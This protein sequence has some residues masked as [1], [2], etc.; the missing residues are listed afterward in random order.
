MR[1]KLSLLL[2]FPG[3]LLMIS[4]LIFP[5][6]LWIREGV[7]ENG[8]YDL[9]KCDA[10]Y[11]KIRA[12][13]T[14]CISPYAISMRSLGFGSIRANVT[15]PIIIAEGHLNFSLRR[16]RSILNSSYELLDRSAIIPAV[17]GGYELRVEGDEVETYDIES[18]REL[19]LTIERTEDG[20][21]AHCGLNSHFEKS[22]P[23]LLIHGNGVT[24]YRVE[25]YGNK[26]N[27]A[28]LILGAVVL[29]SGVVM[30]YAPKRSGRES[31]THSGGTD[32]EA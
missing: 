27:S 3:I 28:L 13:D 25:A 21:Y 31:S 24:E 26:P 11:L 19:N 4:S 14:I 5:P 22:N 15:Q 10:N 16:G 6:L 8:T 20:I 1:E 23:I 30:K 18:M 32:Q 17:R 12:N 2:A 7:I 9:L 29:L